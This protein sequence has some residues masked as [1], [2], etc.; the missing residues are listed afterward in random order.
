MP[1]LP[2]SLAHMLARVRTCQLRAPS[3]IASSSSTCKRRMSGPLSP[4]ANAPRS[5][6]P[7]HCAGARAACTHALRRTAWS[8]RLFPVPIRRLAPMRDT[9]HP[10]LDPSVKLHVS[11]GSRALAVSLALLCLLSSC[12]AQPL[13]TLCLC[14]TPAR[15]SPPTSALRA[16]PVHVSLLLYC[17]SS[18]ACMPT[19]TLAFA[20]LPLSL[21]ASCAPS[22]WLLCTCVPGR[23]LDRLCACHAVRAARPLR[24]ARLARMSHPFRLFSL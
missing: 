17:L 11:F 14:A 20:P 10:Q 8:S 2:D 3:R 16:A 1:Q 13:S 6:V 22:A 19:H 9:L 12:V 5:H 23:H 24:V 7:V 21:F 18:P 4:L 15:C